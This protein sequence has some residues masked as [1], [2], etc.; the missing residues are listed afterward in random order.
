MNEGNATI[1]YYIY[2]R[3]STESEDKQVLSIDSQT[4]ELK[5]IARDNKI[6]VKAIESEAHSAKAPGRPAFNKM[7]KEIEAGKAQGL[8]VWHANR[9]SR[10]SVDTGLIIYLLDIGKLKEVRTPGQIFRDN[11]NDKFLLNLFCSQAKLENDNKGEDV[12][13]GLRTKVQAGVYPAPAPVGYLNDKYAEKGNK[14][15]LPDLEKFDTVRKM[16]DL[17]LTGTYT[18]P[19][20]L[21][22]IN[23]EW[24]F[25]MPSTKKFPGGKLMSRNTLYHIFSS[26]FYYGSFEY[27]LGSGNWI[28]G[29]HKQMITEEEYDKIQVLLGRKGR[30][31]PKSHIFDFTGMMRCGECGGSITA[32]EKFK[33]PQNGKVHRYIYYHCTKRKN[34]DCSQGSIE[35]DELK[36]QIRGTIESLRIPPEFHTFAMKWFRQQ[37]EKESTGRNAV[38]STQQTAYALCLKKIDGYMDMRAAQLIGDEEYNTKM[39][40]LKKEKAHLEELLNDTGDRVNRWLKVGDEMCVFVRDAIEKFNTG[41]LE[42]RKGILATLGQNLILKDKILRIDLENSLL[43]MKIVSKEVIKIHRRLEP[44]KTPIEQKELERLYS[45]NPVMLPG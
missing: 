1:E 35:A 28:K 8:L 25:K 40:V 45:K 5:K 14:T 37:N 19:Q 11:P 30:P 20:L 38:L 29:I 16:W 2:T 26:P 18:V 7:I 27:P 3:K 17:M 43:P 9:L 44:R 6:R 23:K 15:I 32:E 39:A 34:P 24:G 21:N 42:I 13:R 33:R 12:K 4:D 31:R 41:G 22:L 36:K 10:N